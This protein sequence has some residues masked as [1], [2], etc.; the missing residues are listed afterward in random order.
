MWM[1]TTGIVILLL[2]RKRQT[3]KWQAIH[4]DVIQKEITAEDG[5]A[6]SAGRI[7]LREGAESTERTPRVTTA[8]PK[9][10]QAILLA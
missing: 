1:L 9:G 3:P 10:R 4:V 2:A 6:A 7:Y 8:A 5:G